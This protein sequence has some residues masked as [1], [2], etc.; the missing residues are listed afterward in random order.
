MRAAVVHRSR[1]TLAPAG[2]C[3]HG[4]RGIGRAGCPEAPAMPRCGRRAARARPSVP[5][6]WPKQHDGAADNGERSGPARRASPTKAPCAIPARHP[7]TAERVT[8]VLLTKFEPHRR[9]SANPELKGG[10]WSRPHVAPP[11]SPCTKPCVSPLSPSTAPHR[12]RPSSPQPGTPRRPAG[13]TPRQT[14][15]LDPA[16]RRHGVARREASPTR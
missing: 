3:G 10:R 2:S 8:T 9:A 6:S 11:R 13:R 7:C 15:S 4:D 12:G 5:A 1:S 14:E 16:R